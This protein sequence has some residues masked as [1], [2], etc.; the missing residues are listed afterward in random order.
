MLDPRLLRVS[1][2]VGDGKLKVYEGLA[3]EV[4]ASKFA[5]ATQNECEVKITNLD[6]PTRDYLLTELSP[7][8]RNK[9]RKQL[10]VEA[11]R[12]ST[13]YSL[14]YSGDI[15]NLG[16]GKPP[17][18]GKEAQ[19]TGGAVKTAAGKSAPVGQP[20]DITIILKS[21][22]AQHGKGQVVSKSLPSVASLRSIAASAAKDLGLALVYEATDKQVSNYSFTGAATK[23][24][25]HIASAGGVSAYVDD[26]TLVVKNKREA[27]RN[28]VKV[29]D[30]TSG[31]IGIPEFTEHGVKV[32]M[33]YDGQVTLGG[34]LEVKSSL[35][36]AVNGQYVVY[37]LSHELANRD[38][39]WYTIAECLRAQ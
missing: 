20:P 35:N 2:G 14:V 6:K 39:P 36:P 5:N 26:N 13:G 12:E 9:S 22:T 19:A 7:F 30:A 16:S 11:G 18:E 28:R 24:V 17:Q 10:I 32:K 29:L 37:K 34:A 3:M 23:Q 1:I 38:T 27:L 15:T 4:R 31:M 33:L 25:D 21:A 8:N